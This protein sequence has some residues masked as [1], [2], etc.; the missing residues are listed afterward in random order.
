MQLQIENREQYRLVAVRRDGMEVVLISHLTM[1]RAEFIRASLTD[2]R[3][4][5]DIRIEPAEEK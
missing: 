1:A 5:A 3:A 2:A 4:F